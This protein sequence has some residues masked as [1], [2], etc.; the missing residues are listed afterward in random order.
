MDPVEI[1]PPVLSTE[2]LTM[3]K[4]VALSATKLLVTF[5]YPMPSA[6]VVKF[7]ART[8]SAYIF[9]V[10]MELATIVLILK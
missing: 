7:V 2:T 4:L 1:E 9:A 3:L 6:V 8:V 10:L 5:R